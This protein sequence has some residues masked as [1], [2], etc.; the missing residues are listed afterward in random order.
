MDTKK[1]DLNLLVTLEAL[2]SE[3]NVTR[4][5]KRLGLSQP[6]VSA[7]L[8]RLRDVLGD[9]LFVPAQRG[10]IPTAR[11]LELHQP[12]LQALDS[13]R[14]AVSE[15]EVFDPMTAAMTI[16]IAGSDHFQYAWLVPL[17][18][19]L[20]RKAPGLRLALRGPNSDDLE[21]LMERGEID[22]AGLPPRHT[23]GSMMSRALRNERYVFVSRRRH[24]IV[25][26]S[27]NL[28]QFVRLD[29]V[30]AEPHVNSFEGASDIVLRALG[31][32]RRIVLSVSS[33]FAVVEAVACSDLV[34]LVPESVA[35][36]RKDRLQILDPPVRLPD[37][38]LRL[39][40]HQ[41]THDHPAHRWI[42]NELAGQS[43]Q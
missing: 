28:E 17:A 27:I 34:A 29:H 25:K 38:E 9:Q 23:P 19:A 43:M 4:A 21:R 6:A 31:R 32:K 41:R 30:I 24:P 16:T 10:V 18:I 39:V 33:F 2:M 40:W 15:S 3:R 1:L 5:A 13:V 37:V 42:R 14:K 7:Q 12:L 11:A 26:Q 8:A 20:K 35:R 36:G 22:V